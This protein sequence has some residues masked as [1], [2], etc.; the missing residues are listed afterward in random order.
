MMKSDKCIVIA[1]DG[2][3][4]TTLRP[5]AH[6][7]G[8]HRAADSLLARFGLTHRQHEWILVSDETDCGALLQTEASVSPVFYLVRAT[9]AGAS[10]V[11]FD[12]RQ[13]RLKKERDRLRQLS[14]ESDYVRVEEL[15]VLAGS[16]PEHYRVTFFCKGITGIDSG[17]A[18]IYGTNHQVEILCDD[19]FPAD[20]PR[21]RWITP[22]WHPNIQHAEPKGVCV[23]KPEWLGG[24]GLVDLCRLMFEMVQYKNYHAEFTQPYPLDQDVAR[25]VLEYAQPKRIVDK[26]RAIS[27]DDQP[28]TRPTVTRRISMSSGPAGEAAEPRIKLVSVLAAADPTRIR[29][30]GTAESPRPS[31]TPEPPRPSPSVPDSARIRIVKKDE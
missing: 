7:T 29:V 6:G 26:S 2:R 19:D 14:Q 20:V 4:L 1:P 22:I 24:M 28:F 16:E 11:P 17:R 30:L 13:T 31:S 10:R 27:V 3:A 12:P 8:P 23:N 21:L 9:L 15:N 25:W 5:T 18:P